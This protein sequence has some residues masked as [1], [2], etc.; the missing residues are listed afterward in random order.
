MKNM[1]NV[2]VQLSIKNHID[3]PKPKN[4]SASTNVTSE[5]I[6]VFRKLVNK[7]HVSSLLTENLRSAQSGGPIINLLVEDKQDD[8]EHQVNEGASDAAP[9]DASFHSSPRGHTLKLIKD[10]ITRWNSTYYMLARC[11]LLEVPLRKLV[12]EFGLEGSADNDWSTAQL[13]CHFMKPFQ[14]LTDYLQGEKYLT[15]GSLSRKISQLVLY[16]SRPKPPQSWG[17]GKTWADL[18]NAVSCMRDFVLADIKRRWDAG[19]LLVGMTAVVDPRHISL[20][21]MAD[22]STTADNQT[23]TSEGNICCSRVPSD[24][25]AKD[26]SNVPNPT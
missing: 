21:C 14:V 23:A 10:V 12:E 18:P 20:E 26:G 3:P 13:L 2:L 9:K 16:L 15:L 7:I 5:V 1:C 8:G 4:A 17:L 22:T 25:D 19:N 6:I 11:V 24:N